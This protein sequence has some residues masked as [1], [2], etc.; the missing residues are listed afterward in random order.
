MLRI[1]WYR[2]LGVALFFIA[3]FGAFSVFHGK[4]GAKPFVYLKQA[5]T[6]DHKITPARWAVW[7]HQIMEGWDE[8]CRGLAAR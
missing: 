4:I 7:K 2:Q 6:A 8:A 5:L 1:A 3:F